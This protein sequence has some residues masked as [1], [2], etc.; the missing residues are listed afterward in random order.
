M[1][2]ELIT[3]VI[4]Q[5][6]CF[7]EENDCNKKLKEK[8][9]KVISILS[10]NEELAI[11]KALLELEEINSSEVCSYHRTQVWDIISMLESAK[12]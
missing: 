4:E 5:L 6:G 8:S 11:E 7:L 10:N 1:N 12:Q 9:E 2:K 3:E